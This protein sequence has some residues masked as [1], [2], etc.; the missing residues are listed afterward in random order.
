MRN[1]TGWH[2]ANPARKR[3]QV[4]VQKDY[5]GVQMKSSREQFEEWFKS[6]HE[7]V[8]NSQELAAKVMKM[9][10]WSS[11][12]AS[13]SA[14]E[15]ELP[16]ITSAEYESKHIEG[17]FRAEAFWLKIRKNILHMGLNVKS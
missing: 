13:R 17:G 4:Q 10:A 6:E 5:E 3:A 2:D 9:I 7:E 12:Q 16:D 1:D 14:I 11:W 8:D 15:I